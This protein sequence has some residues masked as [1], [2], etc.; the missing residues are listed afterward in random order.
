MLLDTD[1]PYLEPLLFHLRDD[2]KLKSHF[3]EKSFFM[4]KKD[5][6]SAVEDAIKA[7]C[8]A[9]RALWI[10]PQDT[11]A[12]N[13]Q[14]NCKSQGRHTFYI[15]IITQCI[16]DAFQITKKDNK[17][18]LG[19]EYIVLSHLRKLV[20]QSVQEFVAQNS[21]F[22]QNWEKITWMK[23]QILLPDDEG[24]LVTNIEYQITIY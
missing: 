21:N 14:V 24:F 22:N 5:L 4:P 13:Q 9:P 7:D 1:L 19:G 11:I 2:D 20:K 16:R 17:L 18:H 15:T 10:L 12:A 23:D 8:P 3:T 6:I